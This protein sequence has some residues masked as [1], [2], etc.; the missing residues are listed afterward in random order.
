[1]ANDVLLLNRRHRA[2]PEIAQAFLAQRGC[3]L[4]ERE[5]RYPVDEDQLCELL[6]DVDGLITGLDVMTPRVYDH[7]NRL[8][9]VS[10]GGVGYDH[11]NIDEA[12]RRGVAVCICAGCNNHSVAELVFGMM[13]D[14]SRGISAADRAMRA[15]EWPAPNLGPELWGKT[16]GIVGLGRVGKSVALLGRA[17]GMQVLAHDIAWDITF[18]GQN[19]ISYVPF[20]RLLRE[21]DY[22][23]LHTPLTALTRHL[24]D[25]RAIDLMKPSA[26]LI[27]AA[28]GPIVKEWALV[29]AL[30]SGR[31]AGAGLDTFQ[32]EPHADNPYTGFPN[33]VLTPH[34]GGSTGD[35]SERA[36]YLALT[37]VANVLNGQPAHCQVNTL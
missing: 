9:V 2:R 13:I 17:F 22:V 6:R 37:N 21:S 12:T 24:I 33:V 34:I 4:L 20:E 15:G 3:N 35:A 5:V 14:L 29:E 7:A 8:K 25:E 11:I 30:Q 26:I 31:I 18:A 23:T 32:V 28:R 36:Y 1:M 19:G 27:N 16:L 10:A